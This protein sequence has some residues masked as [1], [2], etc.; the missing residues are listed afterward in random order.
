MIEF[1][2]AS[3]KPQRGMHAFR[4][5]NEVGGEHEDHERRPVV[6]SARAEK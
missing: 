2:K 6:L 3:P 1:G 5:R 4:A